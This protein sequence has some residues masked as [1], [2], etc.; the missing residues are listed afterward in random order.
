[1]RTFALLLAFALAACVSLPP[2]EPVEWLDERS[3]VSLGVVAKPVILARERRDVAANA[4]DYLTLAAVERNAAG[5][6]D[7]LLLAHRWTT[8]DRRVDPPD[9]AGARALVLLID[10]R[11]FWLEPLPGA[12]EGELRPRPEL[13]APTVVAVRTVAYRLTRATLDAMAMGHDVIAFF[14]D[15]RG[16]PPFH[17]WRDGK[18]AL[19]RFAASLDGATD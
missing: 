18:D 2:P 8:I 10:G 3:G 9:D 15:A 16:S 11:D 6:R 17:L 13:H 14:A 1:M 7:L 4:R 5:R 12:V 19:Q